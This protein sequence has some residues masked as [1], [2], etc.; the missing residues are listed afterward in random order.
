MIFLIY[1]SLEQEKTK[2]YRYQPEKCK[3]KLAGSCVAKA[4]T[5][6]HTLILYKMQP[7]PTAQYIYLFTVIEVGFYIKFT[8]LVGN[9]DE[10]HY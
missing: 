5:K 4:H 3:N 10:Q 8:E 1:Q 2:D 7:E 6:C 9:D